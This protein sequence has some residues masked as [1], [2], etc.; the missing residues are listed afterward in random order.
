[1]HYL[2]SIVIALLCIQFSICSDSSYDEE[3]LTELQKRFLFTEQEKANMCDLW[4]QSC[5]PT[6][7]CDYKRQ[8]KVGFCVRKKGERASCLTDNECQS[9]NCSWWFQ[10]KGKPKF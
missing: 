5:K 10:C 2:A 7:Y 3:E 1:M 6:H 8:L 9:D 4:F